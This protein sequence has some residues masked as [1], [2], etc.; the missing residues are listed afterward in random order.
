M[1]NTNYKEFIISMKFFKGFIFKN[2]LRLIPITRKMRLRS[3]LVKILKKS[4]IKNNNT[5]LV[6]TTQ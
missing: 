3:L 1:T 4:F 6:E 2:E 5:K